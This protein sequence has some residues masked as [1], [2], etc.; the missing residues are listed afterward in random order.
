MFWSQIKNEK[1]FKYKKVS[2]GFY[3]KT[4]INRKVKTAKDHGKKFFSNPVASFC[5]I[6]FYMLTHKQQNTL[7]LTTIIK[8]AV[9]YFCYCCCLCL[10]SSLI[11]APSVFVPDKMALISYI[12]YICRK[13][14]GLSIM[15]VISYIS[16]PFCY[17][18]FSKDLEFDCLLMER[19]AM[20]HQWKLSFS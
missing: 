7:K 1:S 4:L 2:Y 11:S 17:G 14:D 15:A 3:L 8:I 9:H 16:Q 6:V 13:S 20:E 18:I 5:E 12:E 10:T 19:V